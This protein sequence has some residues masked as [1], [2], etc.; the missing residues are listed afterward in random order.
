[1]FN[2]ANH[3]GTLVGSVYVLVTDNKDAIG[4][5]LASLLLT[6]NVFHTMF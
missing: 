6:L 2:H 4:V 5:V 3:G 1:M